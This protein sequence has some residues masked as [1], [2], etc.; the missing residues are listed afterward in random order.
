[1]FN[2]QKIAELETAKEQL[3]RQYNLVHGL[4]L[5]RQDEVVAL[6]RE[7]T[8]LKIRE[9]KSKLPVHFFSDFEEKVGEIVNHRT[10]NI[11]ASYIPE[12]IATDLIDYL[13]YKLDSDS[14]SD[15]DSEDED[16]DDY[17]DSDFTDPNEDED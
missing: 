7:I 10:H 17:Y 13:K 9:P 6:L 14:D 8:L 15:S 11:L 1:M 2:K 3:Q 12:Q 16:E 4:L 5:Q